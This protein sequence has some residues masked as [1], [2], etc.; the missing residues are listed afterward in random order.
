MKNLTTQ[1]ITF[2]D[3]ATISQEGKLSILGIFDRISVNQFPGGVPQAFFV[4]IVKGEP[5]TARHLSITGELGNETIFPAINMDIRTSDNG[6]ANILMNL[7]NFGFPKEGKYHFV[8]YEG[9]EKIGSTHID[10]IQAQKTTATYKL[11][12]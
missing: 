12:N 9:K 8:L 7:A 1:L 3:Y 5:E 2:A 4:A 10:V 6:Q 11:P